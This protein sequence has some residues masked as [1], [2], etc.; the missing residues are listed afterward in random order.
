M[1]F[2]ATCNA[3][4]QHDLVSWLLRV[5][6]PLA[7]SKQGTHVVQKLLEDCQKAE[8]ERITDVLK[9]HIR[10]LYESPNGNHA[11]AKI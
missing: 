1:D 7:L 10:D 4:E 9:P 5:M 8:K 2:I 3:Q 11:L 6:K